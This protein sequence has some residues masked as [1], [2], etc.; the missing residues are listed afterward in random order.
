MGAATGISYRLTSAPDP[1]TK[2][3]NHSVCFCYWIATKVSATFCQLKFSSV[4]YLWV[5]NP[6]FVSRIFKIVRFSIA[7]LLCSFIHLQAPALPQL[8][9]H[10]NVCLGVV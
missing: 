10:Y 8:I 4:C 9:T 1:A 3:S 6:S 5:A 2:I 7:C